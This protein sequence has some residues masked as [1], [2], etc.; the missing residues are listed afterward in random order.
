MRLQPVLM[1]LIYPDQLAFLPM[2]YILDN[3]F[4]TQETILHT[5]QTNQPLLFLKLDFLKAYDK[6]DLRFLFQ[7]LTRLGFSFAFIDMVRLL[8]QDAAAHVSINGK[9]TAAYS[10][11]QGVRQ[12]CPLVPY[13]FLVIGKILN[14]CIKCEAC[15][16]RIQGIEIP[17]AHE[18]QIMAQ[19]ADDTSLFVTAEELPVHATRDTLQSFCTASGL[20]I[21][22]KKN[23]AYF[24]H[25]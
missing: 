6:V 18:P 4:L 2:R 17:G 20:L 7:S 12:G 11:Q 9:S 22:E 14:H 24:W 15:Q 5:K 25:P 23:S 16:G 13:F 10:I 19:F 3:I 1:E 8:F 21:N